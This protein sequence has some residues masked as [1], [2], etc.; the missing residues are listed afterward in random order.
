MNLEE[1]VKWVSDN[2]GKSVLITSHQNVDPD[3]LCSAFALAEWLKDKWNSKIILSFDSLNKI[4]KKIVKEFNLEITEQSD[5]DNIDSIF[6]LDMSSISKTGSIQEKIPKKIQNKISIDHHHVKKEN[7]DYFDH[8]ILDTDVSSTCEI[9]VALFDLD[10][11]V[12]SK[13]IATLLLIGLIY[14]S[15]RF[16]I[17][18]PVVFSIVQKLLFWGADYEKSIEILQS[19]ME[20]GE[21]IARIKAAQR[22]KKNIINKWVI[23]TSKIGSYEASCCRSLINLGADVAAVYLEKEN[24][25]RISIRGTREFVNKTGIDLSKDVM[26]YIGPVIDGVG[27]GHVNAAGANGKKNGKEGIKKI[28]EIL[29]KKIS[30]E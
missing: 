30:S 10:N 2:K 7:S 8:I 13:E 23:L 4:S 16:M 29:K 11:F 15:R 12:P 9:I 22:M 5:F 25:V 3:G 18:K 6:V 19:K 20:H 28:I 26:E 14:D 21:K 24:V 1:F 17:S 27:G